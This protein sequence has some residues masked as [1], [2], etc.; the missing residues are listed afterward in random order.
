MG[1]REIV[2]LFG[3]VEA[4]DAAELDVKDAAGVQRYGLFGVMRC[5]DAFVDWIVSPPDFAP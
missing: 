1:V 2:N 4:A 3:G 5:A